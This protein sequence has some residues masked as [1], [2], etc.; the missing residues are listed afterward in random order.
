MVAGCAGISELDR[1]A[2]G[3]AIMNGGRLS[4]PERGRAHVF[5]APASRLHQCTQRLQI[6]RVPFPPIR[7]F[8][9]GRLENLRNVSPAFVAHDRAEAVEADLAAADVIVAID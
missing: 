7:R 9:L 2:E 8:L 6:H 3:G 1:L 5:R 4:T